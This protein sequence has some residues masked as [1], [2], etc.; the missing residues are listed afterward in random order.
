M[1]A[2]SWNYQRL[3]SRSPVDSKAHRI[4]RTK[5][6]AL[7]TFRVVIRVGSVLHPSHELKIRRVTWLGSAEET[8]GE[9]W[10]AKSEVL[11]P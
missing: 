4:L 6:N 5:E 3:L 8:A 7:L 10:V 11:V 2:E 9:G 1:K